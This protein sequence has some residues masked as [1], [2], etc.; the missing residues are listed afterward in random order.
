MKRGK[1]DFWVIVITVFLSRLPKR[2]KLRKPI[3]IRRGLDMELHEQPQRIQTLDRRF[4][5]RWCC[6]RLSQSLQCL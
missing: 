5:E 6:E 1:S 2:L 3:W 4:A